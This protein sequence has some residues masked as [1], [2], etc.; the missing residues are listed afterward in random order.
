MTLVH[1]G[2][3]LNY[4]SANGILSFIRELK[5]DYLNQHMILANER[6]WL[7]HSDRNLQKLF[8]LG[9]RVRMVESTFFREPWNLDSLR[10]ALSSLH[11]RH[12]PSLFLTH[13]GFSALA[14]KSE[15]IPFQHICHGFGMNRPV[16]M[17]EQD[18]NGIAGAHK[19]VAVSRDIRS[20]LLKIGIDEQ[21]IEVAYYPLR[22]HSKLAPK[23]G[24]I[25]EIAMIGNLV[26][27][28]GQKLGI[29]T[30]HALHLKN[31]NLRLHV[32]GDGQI[33][34]AHV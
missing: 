15:G 10:A 33:G 25:R 9:V 17:D 26:P 13:G 7:R 32:Y 6:S 11:R 2:Q 23:K 8:D 24:P 5:K 21:K 30:F 12:S 18:R 1:L 31:P 29:D 19:V 20:Q 3:I 27:L 22:P 16:W 34:R 14:C 4:G 28:K